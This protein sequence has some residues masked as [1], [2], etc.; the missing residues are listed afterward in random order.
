MIN[1]IVR[2]ISYASACLLALL[3]PA[4]SA[5]AGS[6]VHAS[7]PFVSIGPK[8]THVGGVVGHQIL[9][10]C[11]LGL[12]EPDFV[13]YDPTQ[14]RHAYTIDSVLNA[15]YTGAGHTIVIV[16][17][18]QSPTLND[19]V[20]TFSANYGLPLT[21]SGYLTQVAPNG[22]VP[23][24][25]GDTNMVGWS[26]EITLD[27]SWAHAIAPAA[28]IVL[29]LAKTNDDGDIFNAVKYAVDNNLGD[30]ISMSFGENESCTDPDLVSQYHDVFTAATQKGITLFASS[31][32]Q[33]AAQPTCNGSSWVRAASHPA[34][35]PLVTGVGGTE[36]HAAYY[37][38]GLPPPFPA[39][40]PNTSPAPGT[41][42]GEIAWNE[43]PGTADPDNSGSTGGGFSVLF[44]EPPYQKATLP[45]GKQRAVPDVAYSS[46][47]LHGVLVRWSVLGIAIPGFCDPSDPTDC[48]FL[49]GGTSAGSPQ[50]AGMTVLANQKAGKRL[51]FLNSAIYQ[52][53]K[54][55][56]AY[57][58]SFH[59]ITSG[60]NSVI[61][62]DASNKPVFVAGFAAGPGWDATTGIGSPIDTSLVDY[63]IR[64]VSPGDGQAAISTTKPKPHP[65]PAVPGSMKPQ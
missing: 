50:W 37:C 22:S 18:F 7:S 5:Q 14:I 60:N 17:A 61:E 21:S 15:G 39:C 62:L 9:F 43:P 19:D 25:F 2:F 41:Y 48:W 16:D 23:F 6:R 59:D 54:V 28:K 58:S 52:I 46:A 10:T 12:F 45:G 13:C 29:V 32:D 30:V 33:G 57:P 26:S 42:Q 44:D 64:Y 40:D 4:L 36:L 56:K 34:S 63:L 55:N 8:A 31:G 51:G 11:Q 53:G 1:P 65:K 3:A 27:V 35:D 49:F 38:F 47:V 20:D 24:D